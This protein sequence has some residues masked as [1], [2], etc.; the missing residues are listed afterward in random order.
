MKVL[1]SG[2]DSQGRWHLWW[3]SFK[4]I[5]L[6]KA[7]CKSLVGAWCLFSPILCFPDS[8]KMLWSDFKVTGIRLFQVFFGPRC[9]Y[10]PALH[11]RFF[12]TTDLTSFFLWQ[13]A[14]MCVD[15]CQTTSTPQCAHTHFRQKAAI[16][17]FMS[18]SIIHIYKSHNIYV[19][20]ISFFSTRHL[21]GCSHMNHSN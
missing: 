4:M 13:Q 8:H 11:F 15:A 14:P 7:M 1:M 21:V 6:I 19:I 10:R 17:M 9:R 12:I 5:F 18:P 20:I 3:L 2:C 16:T